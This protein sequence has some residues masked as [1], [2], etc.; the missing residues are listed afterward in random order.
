MSR[1]MK[2]EEL[3]AELAKV[4]SLAGNTCVLIEGMTW[5]GRALNRQIE[6]KR[7]EVEPLVKLPR[8][9]TAE[10]GAKSLLIGEFFEL[11]QISCP[12]C[13]G[14][15]DYGPC[16]VCNSQGIIS[17]KVAVQWSTIKDIYAKI[18]E[19]LTV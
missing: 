11:C 12:E 3:Q 18:V 17:Q 6:L 15:E 7:Q 19:R 16:S 9:L 8:A 1:M 10:N 5:G 4:H 2:L 14:E 13:A